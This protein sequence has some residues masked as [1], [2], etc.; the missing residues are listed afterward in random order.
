MGDLIRLSDHFVMNLP[1]AIPISPVT[2]SNWEGI[3]V[4]PDIKTPKESALINAHIQALEKLIEISKDE[5]AR[6][7][8]KKSL[9]QLKRKQ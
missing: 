3:G 1:V 4:K 9:Q 5:T 2:K 8:L 7:K 6:Q